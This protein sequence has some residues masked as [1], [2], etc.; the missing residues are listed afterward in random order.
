MLAADEDTRRRTRAGTRTHRNKLSGFQT[1]ASTQL[2][3]NTQQSVSQEMKNTSWYFRARFAQKAGWW[4]GKNANTANSA[5]THQLQTSLGFL[6]TWSKYLRRTPDDCQR[7]THNSHKIIQQSRGENQLKAL[8]RTLY[9]GKAAE[10][11]GKRANAA[12]STFTLAPV[13]SVSR[14]LLSTWARS[15]FVQHTKRLPAPH[16]TVTS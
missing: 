7:P 9:R 5:H 2:T 14:P 11:E 12:D 13:A 8:P 3:L 1:T 16:P 6:L 10:W 15:R 4:E